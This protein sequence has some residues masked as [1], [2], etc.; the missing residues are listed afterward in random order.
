MDAAVV[1]AVVGG[2]CAN[3]DDTK[4]IYCIGLQSTVLKIEMHHPICH[5][6]HTHEIYVRQFLGNQIFI[7][8]V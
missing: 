6:T 1:V 3:G 5:H 2:C 4:L 7:V 8:C